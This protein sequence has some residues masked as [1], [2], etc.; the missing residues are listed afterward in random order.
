M[1]LY[2]Y[3]LYYTG[4]DQ[5]TERYGVGI[6]LRK[7]ISKSVTNFGPLSNRTMLYN[8]CKPNHTI[9]TLHRYIYTY[10]R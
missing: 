10:L 7:E 9:L 1:I 3:A 2:E 6:L 5:P 4:D 8:H